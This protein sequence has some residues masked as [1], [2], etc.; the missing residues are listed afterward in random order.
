MV[1]LTGYLEFKGI[2]FVRAGNRTQ[3]KGVCRCYFLRLESGKLSLSR[4]LAQKLTPS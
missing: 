1:T 2:F 3:A 4:V